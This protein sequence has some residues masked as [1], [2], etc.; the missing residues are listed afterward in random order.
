MDK[1][2]FYMVCFNSSQRAIQVHRQLAKNHNNIRLVPV[3][4]EIR[5]TCGIGIKIVLDQFDAIKSS[6]TQEDIY[7]VEKIGHI[8]NV[9]KWEKDDLL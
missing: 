4:P 7:V 8:R 9:R 6:I 2:T 1:E 3:P 5:V